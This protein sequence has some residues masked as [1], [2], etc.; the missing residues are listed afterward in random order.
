MLQVSGHLKVALDHALDITFS[1]L[2]PQLAADP[3]FA[4]VKV[5]RKPHALGMV[6]ECRPIESSAAIL[7][8]NV[9]RTSFTS[10]IGLD[11]RIQKV[12]TR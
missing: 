1:K 8:L 12:D 7:E 11:M 4:D 6:V 3:E 5:P 2:S 10:T 9:P